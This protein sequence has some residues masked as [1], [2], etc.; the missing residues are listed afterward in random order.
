MDIFFFPDTAYNCTVISTF[1]PV[2]SKYLR[3]EQKGVAKT[4]ACLIQVN[5][6]LFD[7]FRIHKCDLL[8]EVIA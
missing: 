2:L 8:I 1:Q 5:F 6:Q 4:G 7:F 3:E